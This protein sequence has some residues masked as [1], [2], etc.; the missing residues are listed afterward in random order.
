MQRSSQRLRVDPR[1]DAQF[2][3]VLAALLDERE[4]VLGEPPRLLAGEGAE[5]VEVAASVVSTSFCSASK[6]KRGRPGNTYT[7]RTC[8]P[9]PCLRNERSRGTAIV[10]DFLKSLFWLR[11][12]A[13]VVITLFEVLKVREDEWMQEPAQ[14]TPSSRGVA[15]ANRAI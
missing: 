5:Q 2:L 1:H 15:S 12:R 4:D 13:R 6:R 10:L 9:E 14:I 3:L 8:G 11:I 7:S